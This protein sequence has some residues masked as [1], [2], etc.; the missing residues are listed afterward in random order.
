[1]GGLGSTAAVALGRIGIGRLILV[2]F[3]VVEPSNLNRQ[4]YLVEHIGKAKT[5]AMTGLLE[6]INPFVRVDAH[7][8][9]L[10]P[11]NIPDLFRTADVILECF[12]RAEAKIMLLETVTRSLPNTWLVLASGVA[13]YG[14]GNDIRARRLD[15]R[16]FVVGDMVSGVEPGRGLM[17]PRVGIAAHQQADLAAALILDA[18][19]AVSRIPEAVDPIL[20]R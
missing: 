2:D 15:R 5:E 6:R 19:A 11:D 16:V 17:A 1:L 14:N 3:D 20:G 10:T 8:E 4:A 9:E 7:K 13:G 18:E 12:D